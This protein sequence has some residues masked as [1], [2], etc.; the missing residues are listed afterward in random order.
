MST[1]NVQPFPHGVSTRPVKGL[2]SLIRLM[3]GKEGTS[4]HPVLSLLLYG[5]EGRMQGI[6][7]SLGGKL[8]LVATAI[9]L[10]CLLLFS[11]IGW[12]MLGFFSEYQA[13]RDAQSHLSLIQAAYNTQTQLLI[14]Q[15]QQVAQQPQ[16][17]RQLTQRATTQAS[18]LVADAQEA[19]TPAAST[20]QT[21]AQNTL[22]DLLEQTALARHLSTLILLDTQQH[23]ITHGGRTLMPSTQMQLAALIKQAAQ[24]KPTLTIQALQQPV[25]STAGSSQTTTS[26]S[27]VIAQPV[28]NARQSTQGILLA[29]Q[30]IDTFFVQTLAQ[31]SGKPVVICQDE[32]VLAASTLAQQPTSQQDSRF[33]SICQAKQATITTLPQRTLVQAQTL[34]LTVHFQPHTRFILPSTTPLLTAAT[35]EPLLPVSSQPSSQLLILLGAGLIVLALGVSLYTLYTSTILIRPLRRLQAQAQLLIQGQQEHEIKQIAPPHS[36]EL[37]QLTQAFT[38]LTESLYGESQILIDQMSKLLSINDAMMSTLNLEQLLG[39]FVT[40]I[41]SMMQ[42]KHVTLLL[43]GRESIVPWAVAQWQD[44]QQDQDQVPHNS[45]V[46]IDPRNDISMAATSKMAAIPKSG[47]SKSR[48]GQHSTDPVHRI[49]PKAAYGESAT[50]IPHTAL[51]ELDRILARMAL[52]RHRIVFGEDIAA[53]YQQRKEY[54]AQ[55]ALNDGYQSAITVPL[56]LQDQAIG[57]FILYRD[58]VHM[59]SDQEKFLLSTASLQTAMA[60]E[61]ALLFAEVKHKN[62]A[63]ERANQLKSQF[64]ANVTHE[65][66]T[67]LHSIISYGA[68]ILDGFADGSLT[69]EQEQDIQF[70]VRSAEELSQLVD[71]LLDLSKIEADRL[72]VKTEPLELAPRLEKVVE[73]L[74]P[75]AQEKQ[76]ALNL[77]V[78]EALPQVLADSQRLRQVVTNLVSNALKFTEHGGV[79]IRCSYLRRQEMLRV[80]ISDTGIG[81][82]PAA[83]EYIFEAFRQAD[84]STTRRFGGTG[85]GLAI[86]R[87]LIELQGGEITVESVPG[88]GSTFSFSLPIAQTLA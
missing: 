86:A 51:R 21:A 49:Q 24:G 55:L 37:Q 47:K 32:H 33:S 71:D 83:L 79:T 31:R 75:L 59:I 2:A 44:A 23:G 45:T 20:T 18:D 22:Q 13:R 62:S 36:Q 72:E 61:N 41:G 54:W 66:R 8:I 6:I 74:K 84:G 52:T 35:L 10:L 64:L 4:W 16:V 42:A 30:P 17:A 67:P 57:A 27:L 3:R 39:E 1:I 78:E 43:Y 12:S 82:S 77:E 40:Q 80:A 69:A 28:V 14:Q 58:Q 9:L 87:K 76:L 5:R 85:L 11:L 46:Y 7:R 34:T 60:I 15:L 25:A 50:R 29:L 65:L 81:I 56:L 73:Q 48:S 26:W 63:L 38:T 19:E 68:F 70:I 53:I 88:E